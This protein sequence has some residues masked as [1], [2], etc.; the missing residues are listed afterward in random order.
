M[1]WSRQLKRESKCS[2]DSGDRTT[3]AANEKV[4]S[5]EVVDAIKMVETVDVEDTVRMIDVVTWQR[6]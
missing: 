5:A 3:V 4:K 1:R 6:M 2:R